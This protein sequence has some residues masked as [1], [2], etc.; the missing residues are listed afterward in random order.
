MPLG[1][2]AGE[3][4]YAFPNSTDEYL[5]IPGEKLKIVDNS[6]IIQ[7]TTEL[8]ETPYLDKI[9]LMATKDE[10]LCEQVGIFTPKPISMT[11]LSA[12]EVGFVIAGIKELSSAK[13]GDT[14]TLSKEKA[15]EPLPGT[16]CRT[17]L[18]IPQI[19]PTRLCRPLTKS[20]QQ[21]WLESGNIICSN[22]DIY[23][24]FIKLVQ[25]KLP[26]ELKS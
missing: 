13:V 23:E 16:Y 22:P 12:G 17:I 19:S 25:K 7:F 20:E 1:I 9:H 24:P 5:R 18:Q 10:Y 21:D 11:S 15:M 26:K 3:P 6:Y 4:L 8:W 14:I 2:M